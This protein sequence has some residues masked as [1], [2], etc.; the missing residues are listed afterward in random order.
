MNPNGS[1]THRGSIVDQFSRQAEPFSRWRDQS[2]DESLRLLLRAT[3]V[4]PD[5]TVLDVACGPGLVALAFAAAAGHVTGIDVTPAMIDRARA[6]Q[7]N[8][9]LH[10][11]AWAIGDADN[12]PFEDA[13]FT[14][15][16]CRYALHHVLA[17]AAV[18]AEMVRA[19]APGGRVALVD[20]VTSAKTEAAYN[21]LER[22]RDPSH[23]RA[24]RR[25]ALLGLARGSG[26]T[27]VRA[28]SYTADFELEA[29]LGA[30]F[31]APGDAARVR[32]MLVNDLGQD[33]LGVIVARRET[34]ISISYPIAL[35][36]GEVRRR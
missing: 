33:R 23:V 32:A 21:H 19:C 4:T 34:G 10:N 22:L 6:L 36:V 14:V 15:V 31:P 2:H 17:P 5:D 24:V 18:I 16:A 9:G 1:P 27:R 35:V 12:L 25:G 30:S 7:A 11:V 28:M 13:A 26:L 29:L 3:R 20:V 8:R